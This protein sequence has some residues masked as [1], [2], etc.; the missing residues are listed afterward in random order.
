MAIASAPARRRSR[1]RSDRCCYSGDYRRAL[2]R[3]PGLGGLAP[4]APEIVPFANAVEHDMGPI[5]VDTIGRMVFFNA[6]RHI[7]ARRRL[8]T[9]REN[10]ALHMPRYLKTEK[11]QYGRQ[12]V[13]IAGGNRRAVSR[14][15]PCALQGKPSA[16]F[17]FMK[18][19]MHAAAFGI[20]AV[21][22]RAAVD[23]KTV[24][25]IV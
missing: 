5:S 11:V 21:V 18:T 16:D 20:A 13:D 6:F 10:P 4:G 8:Q 25:R 14:S 15:Y 19:T 23:A 12:D 3:C 1:R 9:F 17:A 7:I 2:Y 22:N 24:V